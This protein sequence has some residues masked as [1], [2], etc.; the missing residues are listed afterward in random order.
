MR[1]IAYILAL[2]IASQRVLADT[3]D[4]IVIGS[5]PGGLVAAEYL[6]RNSS[7][8]V[9]VLEAGLP[10]L[11]ASGGTD[12]PSY[13]ASQGLTRFD[14]P[15]EY[16][17]VAFSGNGQYRIGT[18][19]IAS[20]SPL[21]LGKVIGGCSS[22]NGMLYFRPPDSYVSEASW[23]YDVNSVNQGFAA[24]ETMFGYT[25][26]PSTDSKWYNQQAYNIMSSVFGSGSYTQ[27]NAINTDRNSKSKSYG[28]PPFNIKNGLRDSPAKTF[29]GAAKARSNFKILSSA[30]VSYI[31][32][33][34]GKAS[35]VVYQYQ[36]QTITAT[37]SS[38]GAVVVA[39]GAAMTPKIL[40]QSGI[41]PSSQ[42]QMLS[43]NAN[44]PGIGGVPSKWAV[45]ENVGSGLF[46]TAS[47][48]MTFSRNDMVAFD[49]SQS[50]QAAIQQYMTQGHTGPWASP[51]PVMIAYENINLSNRQYQFQVT[52]FS[53]GFA[54]GSNDFGLALYVNNPLGRDAARF[55][56]DGSYHLDTQHSLYSDT[57]DRAAMATYLDKLRGWLSSQGVSQVSPSSG[58][59]STDFVNSKIGGTNHYGGSCY[60]SSDTS[61]SKRCADSSF[62]VIGTS[63]IFVADASLM[64]TG[65]VNPFG[66]I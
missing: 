29:L 35:G 51:D 42:L 44:F 48:L 62:R 61:D 1:I 12:I 16:V 5:G 23:P 9:L 37:L 47:V 26:T 53:H 56:S 4:V 63:N 11:A 24:I 66:F 50:Q 49:Y 7:L 6:S 64:K 40:I 17:G 38:R 27:T 20:P 55:T 21:Y 30:T 59:S 58:T 39:G 33:A 43:N 2:A 3:Y 36:G 13:A 65:T 19:W 46:D 60:T 25:Y 10:S 45:N 54:G 41:G 18:D 57:T 22:L 32:Q 15:G 52:A 8:S 31:I 28:H 14:I 34:Q